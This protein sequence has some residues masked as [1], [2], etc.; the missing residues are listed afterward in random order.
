MNFAPLWDATE[1]LSAFLAVGELLT[2][3]SSSCSDSPAPSTIALV[4]LERSS[5]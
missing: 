2:S 4:P 1:N 3:S 5:S